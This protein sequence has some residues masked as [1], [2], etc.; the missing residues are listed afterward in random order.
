MIATATADE[1]HS[2]KDDNTGT[3]TKA[4]NPATVRTSGTKGMAW[5]Q[6]QKC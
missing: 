1:S 5:Q 2:R 6:Q 4:G 3:P